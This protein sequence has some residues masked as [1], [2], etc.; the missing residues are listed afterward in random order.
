[1]DITHITAMD[2][3]HI[4]N[5]KSGR[6]NPRGKKKNI[7]IL[8]TYILKFYSDEPFEVENNMQHEKHIKSVLLYVTVKNTHQIL[9]RIFKILNAHIYI[10]M[11]FPAISL[12]KNYTRSSS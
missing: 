5:H 4:Q 8:G 3:D 1:M 2:Y 7:V 11:E 10:Y 12:Q 9:K 6:S